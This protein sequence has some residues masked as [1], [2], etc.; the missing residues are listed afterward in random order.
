M[1]LGVKVN[2]E[3]WAES[4]K[5]GFKVAF[6]SLIGRKIASWGVKIIGVV[7]ITVE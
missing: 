7:L 6:G 4:V 5:G 2:G 3:G 1:D